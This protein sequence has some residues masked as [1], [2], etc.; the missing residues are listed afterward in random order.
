MARKAGGRSTLLGKPSTLGVEMA[1]NRMRL[2]PENIAVV[3]DDPKLEI[4]MARRA[5][6][7]AIGVTT[8]IATREMFLALP[9]DLKAHEILA[10][11]GDLH[12]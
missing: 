3:G 12:G 10:S 9:D 11:V 6:A 7:Y 1:C 8:G 4:S 5:G 2:A